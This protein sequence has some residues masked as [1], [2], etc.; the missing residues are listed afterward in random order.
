MTVCPGFN[1][2]DLLGGLNYTQS[3]PVLDRAQRVERF[4]LDEEVHAFRRQMIDSD[5]RR[6]ADRLE[7]TLIFPPHGIPYTC[8]D[9]EIRASAR[10]TCLASTGGRS[11]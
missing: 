2:P 6:I 7:D 11:P 8:R 10:R 4:N 3:Q 5:H 9:H 1:S